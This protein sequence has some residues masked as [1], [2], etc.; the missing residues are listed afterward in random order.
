MFR[1]LLPFVIILGLIVAAMAFEGRSPRAD[2]VVAQATDCFTLDPQ[3]M[4]YTQDLRMARAL[5][6]GLLRIDGLTGAIEPAVAERWEKLDNGKRWRFHLRDDARW[7]NGELVTT[8]DFL[9]AWRRGM[10]PDTAGNYSNIFFHIEGAEDFFNWRAQAT[11]DYEASDT[12]T[13][14]AAEALRTETLERFR[15]TVGLHAVDARTLEVTLRRPIPYFLDLCAFGTMLPVHAASVESNV[16]VDPD[17]GMFRQRH[18]WTKA[19]AHVSNGPYVLERWRYKRDLRLRANPFWWDRDSM[20]NETVEIRC[21]QDPNTAV[22]AFESGELDW[23]TDVMV[24]YRSAM[25]Q[26]ASNYLATHEDTLEKALAAGATMDEALA[27]SPEPGP[28]ERRNLHNIPAFGTFYF[29]FNC[30][31]Q[32]TDGRDNPLANPQV[33][34]ALALAIDRSAIIALVLRTGEPVARSF[35]PPDSI[36]GYVSQLGPRFNPEEARAELEAAGWVDRDGD[37]VPENENGTPFPAI[38]MLYSSGNARYRDMALVMREMWSANLGVETT[39]RSKDTKAYKE[40]LRRGNFMVARGGWY[41]DYGDP[42]TFL[43]LGRSTDGN[44][45]RAFKSDVYDELLDSAAQ[46][47]DPAQRMEIL[48]TAERM[49]MREAVPLLTIYHYTMPYLF[50]PTRLRGITRHPR[51]QQNYYLLEDT[52]KRGESPERGEYNAR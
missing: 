4:T 15:N 1:L 52:S 30:R 28:D 29:N 3:R 44:N 16:S 35:V 23:V 25:I 40:D 9:Y 38:D 51:L 33:R 47:T 34:R 10:T 37:G 7:S 41:G 13:P 42:T 39:L 18:N 17:T 32:L 36:P 31:D 50:D 8:E 46:C 12:H 49:L 45:I 19:G 48:Q 2:I 11:A 5:Y 20:R 14:D 22:L 24:E 27:K 21:I 6:E 26:Q 43:D